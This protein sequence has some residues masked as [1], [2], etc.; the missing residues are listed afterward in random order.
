MLDR[1]DSP[2]INPTL[3]PDVGDDFAPGSPPVSFQMV[4]LL[5][6]IDASGEFAVADS[7]VDLGNDSLPMDLSAYGNGGGS[8]VFRLREG[9]ERFLISDINSPAETN[10]AQSDIPILADLVSTSIE[11][12]NHVPGGSNV[13]FMDGHVSFFKYPGP[14]LVSP[15]VASLIGGLG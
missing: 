12:Y 9:I 8:T 5:F 13:L 2:D 6:T 10:K 11:A 14:H 3:L 15:A 1:A 7:D 4:G